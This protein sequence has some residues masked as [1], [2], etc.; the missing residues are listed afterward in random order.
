[1]AANALSGLQ[2]QIAGQISAASSG[3]KHN[4]GSRPEHHQAQKS[5]PEFPHCQL[6]RG[7]A[8]WRL[9]PYPAYKS[10]P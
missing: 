2:K 5:Q 4:R 1:M 9:T 8:G 3:T 7:V 10:K 6:L